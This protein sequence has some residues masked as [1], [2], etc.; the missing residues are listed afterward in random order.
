LHFLSFLFF[1]RVSVLYFL[2]KLDRGDRH[3]ST[4]HSMAFPG[5]QLKAAQPGQPQFIDEETC[6]C[7]LETVRAARSS[8]EQ[9]SSIEAWRCLGDTSKKGENG[10]SGK[11]FFPINQVA[12]TDT[13][14]GV[15]WN[16][17]PPATSG[18]YVI[19]FNEF[20]VPYFTPSNSTNASELSLQDSVCNG[21]NDTEQSTRYYKSLDGEGSV[22]LCKISPKAVPIPMTDAISWN[23]T[24]CG[25]GFFC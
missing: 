20:G 1:I 18:A 21:R 15:N 22:D 16:G 8:N 17:N 10:S 19:E 13:T 6:L 3:H 14:E 5:S 7:G 23:K 9:R 4:R 12:P 24:G 25:L 11:W 2:I